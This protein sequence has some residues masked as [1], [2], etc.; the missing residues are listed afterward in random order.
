MLFTQADQEKFWS[1]VDRTDEC[2][3]WTR[4]KD[5]DGYGVIQFRGRQWRA[6]RVAYILTYGSAGELF[7]L[8]RCDNRGCVRPDHLFL[9]T[10]D[11]NMADMVAKGRSKKGATNPSHIAGGAY[12]QGEKNGRAK[13]TVEQVLEIRHRAAH[14]YRGVYTDLSREYGISSATV[15][16]IVKG[17]RWKHIAGTVMQVLI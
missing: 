16:D 6:H 8:H 11:D 9:G 13:I 10:N 5:P 4:G 2:W 1:R 7:V 12:Q 15:R 3:N 17:K 14:Y